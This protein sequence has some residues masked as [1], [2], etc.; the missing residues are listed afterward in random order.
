MLSANT[1]L[2]MNLLWGKCACAAYM[3]LIWFHFLSLSFVILK[4]VA[5]IDNIKYMAKSFTQ[6]VLLAS[7]K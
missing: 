1:R 5:V 2:G 7:F 4:L 6:T 3:M